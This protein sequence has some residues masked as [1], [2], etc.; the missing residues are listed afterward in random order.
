M[1]YVVALA[2]E[3]HF[4]RAATLCSVSQSGLS[5]AIRA[6]ENELGT[7]LF[8]RTTRHVAPTDA[9]RALLPFARRMLVQASGGRDAVV[10][11]TRQLSGRLRLGAEQCLG[12]VD[13]GALLERFQLLYPLVDVQFAQ[14]GS[15]EL[16]ARVRAGT[17]DV[18]FVATTEH[19]GALRHMEL[20]RRPVVALVHP[21]D[22][23]AKCPEVSWD[24][25]AGRCFVDFREP[26]GIRQLIDAA[27][28]ER[29]IE[30]RVRIS[31]DDA[32][33]LLDF[34]H[35]GLGIAV[36]PHHI[37]M[38]PQASGLSVLALPQSESTEWVVSA[39][40]SP[41]AEPTALRFL[42]LIDERT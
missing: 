7:P 8:T 41:V 34:V 11:A 25:L 42:D 30:R 23:L 33:T 26:W 5:A 37:A 12:V 36:V 2:E 27:F 24:D 15:Q 14:A 13:A 28:A 39:L 19:H 10:L 16:A 9:G 29:R 38:K 20:G 35:R 17:L 1:E 6:L 21:T 31:V 4:T 18:A 3:G 40:L 32:H 22:E